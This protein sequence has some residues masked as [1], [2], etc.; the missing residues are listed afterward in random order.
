MYHD[1]VQHCMCWLKQPFIN[2]RNFIQIFIHSVVWPEFE[3]V[4]TV[5]ISWLLSTIY[6]KKYRPE[7]IIYITDP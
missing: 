4:V 1:M 7:S 6:Y 5:D 3:T 2:T